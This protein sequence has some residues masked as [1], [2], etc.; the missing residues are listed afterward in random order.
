MLSGEADTNSIVKVTVTVYYNEDAENQMM[1]VPP[2]VYVRDLI[3][4]V[5]HGYRKSNVPIKLLLH[6]F[7]KTQSDMVTD[8]GLSKACNKALEELKQME[9]GW[10]I[11]DDAQKGKKCQKSMVRQFKKFKGRQ[12]GSREMAKRVKMGANMAVLLGNK[13]YIQI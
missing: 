3:Q 2:E 8:E 1:A 4:K 13:T 10:D 6:T 7:E 9:Y 5:N 11:M 12:G